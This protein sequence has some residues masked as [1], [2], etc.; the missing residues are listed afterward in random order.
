MKPK[1]KRKLPSFLLRSEIKRNGSEIFFASM[2]KK[3]FFRLFLHLKQNE[4]EMKRK[5][6]GKEAKTS[7]RKRKSEILGQ[8]VKKRRKIL[9]S[10]F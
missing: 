7:K 1:K 6:N 9:R 10:V 4:N 3:W 2:Q 5:Q 8:S